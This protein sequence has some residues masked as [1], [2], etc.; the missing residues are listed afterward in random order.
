MTRALRAKGRSSGGGDWR[1][2]IVGFLSMD[3][4][5]FRFPSLAPRVE[6]GLPWSLPRPF[7]LSPGFC[8]PVDPYRTGEFRLA[9]SVASHGVVGGGATH[10]MP[11]FVLSKGVFC[12]DKIL[13]ASYLAVH[14]HELS[15]LLHYAHSGL[16]GKKFSPSCFSF[17]AY[18][19]KKKR[20]CVRQARAR[21]ISHTSTHIFIAAV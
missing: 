3:A 9:V 16:T 2:V 4:Q 20:N 17:Y 10:T 6:R 15:V 18:G 5:Q 13:W 19:S 1:C 7:C 14:A 11:G 21:S 12:F 8:F